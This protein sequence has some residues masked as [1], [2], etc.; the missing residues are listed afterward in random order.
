MLHVANRG[1][2]AR[3][4]CP[5]FLV[6]SSVLGFQ[7]PG[8]WFQV[9]GCMHRVPC[10]VFHT[11]GSGFRVP[12]SAFSVPDSTFR[13]PGSRVLIPCSVAGSWFRVPGSGPRVPGFGV[14]SPGLQGLDSV[15]RCRFLVQGSGFM[16]PGSGLRVRSP[17]FG[18]EF[19]GVCFVCL[20]CFDLGYGVCWVFC[21]AVVS[22][23]FFCV[24]GLG[25]EFRASVS[26]F[27]F[28]ARVSNSARVSALGFP[29]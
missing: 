28:D 25:L 8:S 24:C 2:G 23:A 6:P 16:A 22:F 27:R 15:L 20:A 21:V 1:F 12:G 5:G 29:A 13:G 10:S 18:F 7:F 9:Q 4:P 19:E 14:R 3:S 26:G 17:G 11:P